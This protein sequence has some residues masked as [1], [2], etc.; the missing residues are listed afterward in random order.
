MPGLRDKASGFCRRIRFYA[1]GI[2]RSFALRFG[3]R[4]ARLLQIGDR[5]ARFYAGFTVWNLQGRVLRR[6]MRRALPYGSRIV[7]A[8]AS[9]SSVR[10]VRTLS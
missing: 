8:S 10:T 1:Q 9:C 7:R 6:R 5:T 4:K 3:N 2:M